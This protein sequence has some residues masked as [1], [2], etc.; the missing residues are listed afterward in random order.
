MSEPTS[1]MV[2]EDEKE[3]ASL[4][5]AFLERMG[6]DT[7]TFTDPIMALEF[8]KQGTKEFSLILT[9]LRMPEMSGLELAAEIRKFNEKI[10]IILI[11]AFMV[12]DLMISETYKLAKINEIVQKPVKIAALREIID[13]LLQH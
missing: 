8:F 1:I 9:D 6:Y 7:V 12:E 10:K 4:F 2:V 3:L 13:T 5:K 11:T